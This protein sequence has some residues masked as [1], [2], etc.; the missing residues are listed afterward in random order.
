MVGEVGVSTFATVPASAGAGGLTAIVVDYNLFHFT[1]AFKP[2]A[3][4]IERVEELSDAYHL[5]LSEH[6]VVVGYLLEVRRSGERPTN[7]TAPWADSR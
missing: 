3:A 1:E 7:G 4:Q 6:D 5:S 2:S